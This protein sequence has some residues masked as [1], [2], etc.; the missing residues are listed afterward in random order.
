[1]ETGE[2]HDGRAVCPIAPTLYCL[3]EKRDLNFCC[4]FDI[5]F[6]SKTLFTFLSFPTV[7]WR[8]AAY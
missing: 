3:F 6:P 4:A 2:D 1:M 7:F 8:Y 5:S